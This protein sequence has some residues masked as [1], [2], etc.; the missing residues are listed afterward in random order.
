M[1]RLVVYKDTGTVELDTYG[2]ENINITYTVDDLRDVES[3]SGDYSKVFD[4]PATKNNNRYFGHLND[5]QSD[6]TQYDTLNGAK[7][8]LFINQ[9]SVFEGLLYLNEIVN[10]NG[11]TKYKVNLL[12]ESVRLIEALG[13]ATLSDLDFSELSHNFTNANITSAS[14]VSLLNGNTSDAIQYSLIQNLGV[15]GNSNGDIT[16]MVSSTNV[17]PFVR[18][19]NIINKIFAYAG[20]QYDSSFFNST[21]K[22]VFM[23]TGLNDSRIEGTTGT[24]QRVIGHDAS[25]GL[26]VTSSPYIDWLFAADRPPSYSG[27]NFHF[28]A[29]D[30]F[31]FD[32]VHDITTSYTQIPFNHEPANYIANTN[33]PGNIM[34]TNG[35]VTSPSDGFEVAVTMRLQVFATENET[36]S[37]IA[38]QTEAGTGTVTDHDMGSFTMPDIQNSIFFQ[39]GGA[40]QQTITYQNCLFQI[41]SINPV[42]LGAGDT[43]DFRVKKSGGDAWV[44]RYR[45]TWTP[46]QGFAQSVS[47][48]PNA[49]A[50]FLNQGTAA[51]IGVDRFYKGDNAVNGTI[52]DND[53]LNAMCL[54]LTKSTSYNGNYVTV[55]PSGLTPDAIQTRIH[56]NHGDVK[57]A[58]IIKD[59]IKMF[60]LVIE[61]RDGVLKIEP[62]NNFITTGTAKDWSGK[63]DTT[64]ILQNYERVPSKITW[65][66]NNDEDDSVLNQYKAQTGEE[67]GSMTVNLPVDYI[68]EKE[69]KLEVFSA[70]AYVQLSSGLRYS[71]LYA[72]EDG[73]YEQIENKPR[74]ILKHGTLVS[75]NINDLAGIY[76]TQSYRALGHFSK[77]PTALDPASVSLNFG[78][79]QGLYIAPSFTPPLNL[80][81]NYWFNYI[82]ER[83]TAERVLVKCKA[84][85]TETDIQGFSF[86]DTI[87][88]Q[89]QQYRV[90]KIEYSAGRSG[91]A[92][93][94]M[95]K[96]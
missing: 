50:D 21:M 47:N 45:H 58:D 66:Y 22:Q 56:E 51:G 79:T 14:G 88:V 2:D 49:C 3:K 43:L 34:G 70:M 57:L 55:F 28:V 5:L 85:L 72:L 52:S 83:Y 36:I 24:A 80:Y 59:L 6:V 90:V 40:S 23:D 20:F 10:V 95:I 1:I 7:C 84:Y 78:Y 75:A 9:V 32:N 25:Q 38:R 15:V 48:P 53:H 17:Q 30:R 37:V 27:S 74:L 93:L 19:W 18:M 8:E 67:Y 39:Q 62:Y 41:T 11:E 86:A 82:N 33:D 31:Q 68:D 54:S 92:K 64:E 16:E 91:L 94:E 35:L 60:N 46:L 29:S 61:N 13:D 69:I 76:T 63:I 12:G 87:T 89:N 77:Y 81:Q 71:T 44:S 26:S 65:R 73:V 96:I 42:I 4:L